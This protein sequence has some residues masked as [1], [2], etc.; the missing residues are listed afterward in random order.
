M[1]YYKW[2]K[3]VMLYERHILKDLG[4]EFHYL[5]QNPL[6]HLFYY[7]KIVKAGP[8]LA[9]IAWNYLLDCFS[10][11]VSVQFPSNNI[12][13]SCLYLAIRKEQIQMPRLTWWVLAQSSIIHIAQISMAID[14]LQLHTKV[15]LDDL[16]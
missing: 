5:T 14:A 12:A 6:K 7:F 3:K 9:Q 16:T 2:K 13:V 11:P 10:L 15:S 8:E 4:F 1:L